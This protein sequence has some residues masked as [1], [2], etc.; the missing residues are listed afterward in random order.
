M[1]EAL[2]LGAAGLSKTSSSISF[3]PFLHRPDKAEYEN[4]T[5]DLRGIVSSRLI[6]QDVLQLPVKICRLL[7]YARPLN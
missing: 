7:G 2:D 1:I 5:S 4:S 3:H 6:I